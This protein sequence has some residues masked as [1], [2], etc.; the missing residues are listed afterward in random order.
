RKPAH[1]PSRSRRHRRWSSHMCCFPRDYY[2]NPIITNH[3]GPI[4]VSTSW[5]PGEL[6]ERAPALLVPDR[7]RGG[8]LRYLADVLDL[9]ASVARDQ[10]CARVASES[11]CAELQLTPGSAV[12]VYWL[13]AYGPGERPLQVDEAIYP[14]ETWAFRQEYPVTL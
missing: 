6:A 9:R 5:F 2:R 1:R 13:V 7:L 4:E 12:L 3:R 11:E 8:T 14:P 10:V